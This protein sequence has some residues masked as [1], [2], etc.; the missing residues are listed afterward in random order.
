MFQRVGSR[1][2]RAD[3]HATKEKPVHNDSAQIARPA[4]PPRRFRRRHLRPTTRRAPAGR[5]VAIPLAAALLV[6]AAP[7]TSAATPV[8]IRAATHPA[9][10]RLVFEWPEPIEFTEEELG[11]L[12]RLRFAKPLAADLSKVPGDLPGY[13][14]AVRTEGPHE[15]QLTLKPDVVAQAARID[16]HR[17]VVDFTRSAAP[18]S[19][20]A[21]RTGRHEGFERLVFEWGRPVGFDVRENGQELVIAFD[22]RRAVGTA[23]LAG[24]MPSVIARAQTRTTRSS[25]EVALT[26]QPG[27]AVRT[28]KLGADRVVVDLSPQSSSADGGATA[29][30]RHL[31]EALYRKVR[32][33]MADA[34]PTSAVS[35]GE[36]SV[37][38]SSGARWPLALAQLGELVAGQSEPVATPAA[39]PAPDDA[40]A[41]DPELEAL[42]RVLVE[43]GGLLLPVWGAEVSPTIEYTHRGANGL[44]ITDVDGVRQVL[45]QDVRRD[46]FE[47]AL[48]GRLGL[49][50]DLQAEVRVPYI[51]DKEKVSMAGVDR[52]EHDGKGVGDVEVALTHQL[53]REN[54][55]APDLLAEVRYRA[56]TGEDSFSADDDEIAVGSGFHGISGSLTA[57]KSYDPMVFFGSASYTANLEDNKSGFKIDPGDSFGFALGTVLAAGPGASLRLGITQTFTGEAEVE[58]EDIAGSDEV[59]GTFNVGAAVALP[60]RTLLDFAVG[61]GITEDAP[62]LTLKLAL[63]YRF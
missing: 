53:L 27:T 31:I 51:V 13:I 22:E 57:V 49:P 29:G 35:S 5:I 45:A 52:E 62:D 11:R 18:S 40:S 37:V 44:L 6:S 28:F 46:S 34:S 32:Q 2:P 38:A 36:A 43:A 39:A 41:P 50:W 61:I 25:T 30:A 8:E 10:G 47:A 48:T 21:V 42:N 55:V 60:W 7:D 59:V 24:R 63:P 3:S 9:F 19:E 16:D 15:V 26:L 23:Q 14:E 56:P 1:P 33:A 58:G 4:L 54:G 20:V 17:I 12:L